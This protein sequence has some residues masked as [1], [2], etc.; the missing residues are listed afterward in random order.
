MPF[1]QTTRQRRRPVLAAFAVVFYV[2]TAAIVPAG[3]M[4]A[5]MQSG[6]A[7]HLCPGDARSSLILDTLAA[8]H[9]GIASQHEH[10]AGHGNGHSGIQPDDHDHSVSETS[11]DP[12]CVFAG[13]GTALVGSV[14]RIGDAV[15]ATRSLLVPPSTAV[16]RTVAWLRPPA[17]SP[18]A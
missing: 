10:H 17:R 13:V 16:Y 14:D 9:S 7:F 2:L 5:P 4:A 15:I 6:T 1:I 3:H 18:P 8:E 12:G 11:A